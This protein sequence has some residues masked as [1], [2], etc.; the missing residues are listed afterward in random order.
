MQWKGA[1]R[2]YSKSSLAQW[3]E[4]LDGRWEDRFSDAVLKRGRKLYRKGR[5]REIS[6]GGGDA[7]VTCKIGKLENYSV[8]DWVDGQFSIRSSTSDS[9]FAD[10]IAVAGFLEIEELIADEEMSHLEDG[11]PMGT[12]SQITT[13]PLD[14]IKQSKCEEREKRMLHLVLDTHF[15]GLI[16]EAYWL[17]E[18]GRRVPALG[19]VDGAPK[20]ETGEE[21]G[22]LIS[23]AARA[24]KSHFVYSEEFNGYL[25]QNLQEIP[26]FV[27]EVWPVWKRS[28]LTEEREN[29][30]HI[31]SGMTE[32][33][34][35]AKAK[36]REDRKLDLQWFL[37]TGKLNLDEEMTRMLMDGDGVPTLIPELGIVKL[38]SDSRELLS[39]WEDL[40][41][42]NPQGFEPYQLYSL[43]PEQKS[44]IE[45]EGELLKWRTAL[46]ESNNDGEKWLDSLR[47]Y[48]REGVQ[49]M[50]RL[51]ENGCH[52]LLADEMGLG[53][54]LQV[55]ALVKE[56]L[57][58]GKKA[59]I[60]CPASV[61]PVWISEFEKFAPELKA[62][63]YK[64][65]P[66][67][68]EGTGWDAIVTSFAFMRNRI[69]RLVEQ[70][71]EYAI[72]DEAQFI[73]NPDTKV[74]RAALRIKAR[75]RVALSG[76]PIENKPLDI[77]P[78]F[79]FLMPGLLGSRSKFELRQQAN[80]GPFKARLK[81]QIAPFMLRRTKSQVAHD[82]P[83]KIVID[84]LCPVTKRQAK[85]YSAICASGMERLG[86]NF[87][88]ALKGQ[89][90]AALSVL[91]RLRQASCDPSLLPWVESKL[92]DSGKLM[93]LLEKLNE[94]LG[95]GHK[96]VI[97][98][99]FVRFLDRIKALI[100]QSFPELPLFELTGSTR[101]RETPV[102][103]FQSTGDTAAMLVSLRAGGSGITLNAADYVFLMDPWWNPAV[104]NQAIDRV[105]R[106][107][108][109]NT[110]FVYRMI[111][112]GTIE[113][114]IQ[115]L[116]QDKQ[117]LFD[118]IVQN[119]STGAD[120][121]ARQ[122]KSLEALLVLSQAD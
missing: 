11:I 85:E 12:G 40:E 54:T 60:V 57:S 63:R 100:V 83:D 98:S 80:P 109:E 50:H 24:R 120:E 92:E 112:K 7:I 53:K 13:E 93:V 55:I 114:K 76:T 10:A 23:L 113:G 77:W 46:T 33:K 90:F 36:L 41:S 20:A 32:L 88:E 94:V 22:R 110:V 117:E 56:R 25:L 16:C 52:C 69:D 42:E 73:K 115:E 49:W 119:S 103:G 108:Q 48:Q 26:Y 122:F 47:P 61:V 107:G 29:V 65:K 82:L 5:I 78:S 81:M 97:F 43:F 59:L 37:N 28:Y 18:D 21:R 104:E 31:R 99:Q 45:L 8:V 1:S 111:A 106:I 95:T 121:L 4:R 19:G 70:E 105:H 35:A 62:K 68:E 72:I 74:T 87:S 51:L 101:D 15:Q 91:T 89:R 71:F 17:S 14:G 3:G 34:L 118:S 67:S 9:V 2:L 116:K 102:K 6:V 44:N 39:R 86:S 66:V 27:G 64:G 38:S 30:A 96:V 84:Q 75:N 58:A 79:Q